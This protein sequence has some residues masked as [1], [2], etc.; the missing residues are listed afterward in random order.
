LSDRLG[1]FGLPLEQA[2][3][4]KATA[5]RAFGEGDALRDR[6][7][8]FALFALIDNSLKVYRHCEFLSRMR[9]WIMCY[10]L[11]ITIYLDPTGIQG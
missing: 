2:G 6:L 1:A 5:Q 3:N 8:R 10:R 11:W 4:A 7:P 9:Q